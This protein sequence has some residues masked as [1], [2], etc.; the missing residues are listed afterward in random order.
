MLFTKT[1]PFCND[2]IDWLAKLATLLNNVY[3]LLF[4]NKLCSIIKNIL[5]QRASKSL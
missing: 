3:R 4:F 1:T 2:I 5:Q